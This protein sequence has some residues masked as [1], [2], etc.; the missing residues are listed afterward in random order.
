[1]ELLGVAF[2]FWLNFSFEN[3]IGIFSHLQTII[4]R[5]MTGT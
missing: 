5:H 1:M 3:Y 2:S 4:I